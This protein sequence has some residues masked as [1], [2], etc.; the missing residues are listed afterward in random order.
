VQL[1]PG[2]AARCSTNCEETGT[3]A[4]TRSSGFTF[5][6]GPLGV[7]IVVRRRRARDRDRLAARA[8]AEVLS[9]PVSR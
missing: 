1:G 4:S 2:L 5:P 9:T 8:R 7:T 3:V 6:L